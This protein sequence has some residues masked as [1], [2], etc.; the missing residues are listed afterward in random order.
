MQLHKQVDIL[1]NTV[2]ASARLPSL[3][4]LAQENIRFLEKEKVKMQE[5]WQEGEKFFKLWKQDMLADVDHTETVGAF[6]H[7]CILPRCILSP[8]DAMYCAL[9]IRK[10]TLDDTPYFSFLL[11]AKQ[12]ISLQS[13]QSAV[14]FDEPYFSFYWLQSR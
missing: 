13:V 4:W 1:A 8:E 5:R 6:V 3:P 9:F 11:V 14:L 2:S 7:N 12:V 10:L